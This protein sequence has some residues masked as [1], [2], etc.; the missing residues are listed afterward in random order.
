MRM[1]FRFIVP[2]LIILGCTAWGTSPLVGQL[3]HSWLLSDVELR[4][5]LV[6]HS[7]HDTVDVMISTKDDVKM[8]ELFRSIASDE[9][10][11]ALGLC[12]SNRMLMHRS[13]EW[14]KILACPAPEQR[15]VVEHLAAGPVLAAS[16]A[17]SSTESDQR[18]L[19]IVHDL[20]FIERRSS[21]LEN[22]LSVFLGV[23][24]VVVA[25]I[26]A[27]VAQLTLRGWI[28]V[29]YKS[30]TT[31]DQGH[32]H[33][34]LL[35]PEIAPLVREVRKMLRGLD[36]PKSAADAIRIDW[37]PE[38]LRTLLRNELPEAQVIVVSNREPYIHHEEEDGSIVLQRP[39]SGL[40]TA[41]EPI[42]RACGGTWIAH[43]SGSADRRTV[44]ANDRLAVPP[45]APTYTLRR[46]W[47]SDEEQDGYYYG[48]ANA[49]LWPLC[50]IAFV[51]PV[52]RTEDWEQYVAVNRKFADA[53]VAEAKT[54]NPVLLV[55]DYHFALLP[56]MVRERLPNATIITFWHIPWP[57]PEA[58]SIC[59]WREEILWGMLGSSILGF[60]TRFHCLNFLESVDRFLE[61]HID[62]EQ[63]IVST[64][65]S[66][67]VVR[68][69]PISIEWP[70][71][72]L[73]NQC[74]VPVCRAMI[75]QQYG[76]AE[77]TRGAHGAKRSATSPA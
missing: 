10:L 63:S 25:L 65:S 51:R 67:T 52:F 68:P 29:M 57:N 64:G 30:L 44:D 6:F 21:T 43:G 9:R 69:Y 16:F 33:K 40:V 73:A 76:L 50:H 46:L 11:L 31:P 34:K 60:H 18:Y 53:V 54:Q 1:A 32:A 62:R 35:E 7:I 13:P 36:A 4:S 59:P 39:A 56:R 45:G 66:T 61:C 48:L 8:D 49:G 22:Y 37:N 26:T 15:F 74:A 19:V 23:L 72:A 5:Q 27:L 70:P 75:R 12:T 41:L 14:P 24:G 28:Q 17:L 71:T 55:Q 47:L 2:L 3:M 20:T 42:C 58:F 38:S 77:N